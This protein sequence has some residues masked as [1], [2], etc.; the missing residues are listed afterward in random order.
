[1]ANIRY[2]AEALKPLAEITYPAGT[3][4]HQLIND[5]NIPENL[6]DH[7]MVFRNGGLVKDYDLI[8]EEHENLTIAIVQRGGGGGDKNGIM[9]IVASIAIAYA[10]PYAAPALAG[11]TGMSVAVATAAISIVGSLVVSA[12]IPPASL[13]GDT[14]A[15]TQSFE[16]PLAYNLTGQT[17]TA[18][19]YGGVPAI[20]GQIRFF[21]YIGAQTKVVQI[22]KRTVLSSLYDF[23]LGDVLIDGVQIGT[24]P[25]V[26][27]GATFIDHVNTKNPDLKYVT[28]TVGYDQLAFNLSSNELT[29]VTR[30]NADGAALTMVFP[31]GLAKFND[32]GNPTNYSVDLMVEFRKKGTSEW[33]RV[34]ASQFKT[35]TVTVSDRRVDLKVANYDQNFTVSPSKNIRYGNGTDSVSQVQSGEIKCNPN[36]FK[37]GTRQS[38]PDPVLDIDKKIDNKKAP[39]FVMYNNPYPYYNNGGYYG[40]GNGYSG[41]WWFGG[42]YP[43]P[44]PLYQRVSSGQGCYIPDGT[45]TT[46]IFNGATAQ[47]NS[48][49]LEVFF[50]EPDVYEIKVKRESAESTNTR[51]L[52]Q[53][54]IT[55]LETLKNET[56]VVL[57]HPHTLLEMQ[58][59]SSERLTGNVDNLSAFVSKRI[60]TIDENGF[61]DDLIETGNPALIALDIL[62]NDANRE[63]LRDDQIDFASFVD[64]AN[65][66][67]ELVTY[68]QGGKTYTHQK[69]EFNGLVVGS[70]VQEAVNNVLANGRAQLLMLQ[71]GKFGVLIDRPKTIPKQLITPANSWGFK[72]SRS[73]PYYPDALRV[74][75]VD[76]DLN[77]ATTEVTVYSDGFDETN[78]KRF[79]TLK[80]TGIINY[81]QAYRYARYM[82]AQARYR[83]EIFSVNMD[84]ENLS[85]V[86]GDLVLVQ[87]DVPKL[88]GP[89]L[90][91][92][93]VSG[94]TIKFNQRISIPDDASYTVRTLE[95]EVKSGKVVSQLDPS[96]VE[97]ETAD[98]S[99]TPDALLA[100]GVT[101]KV[102]SPYLVLAVSP[103]PDLTATIDLAPYSEEVYEEGDLP[104]WNPNF[105][106]DLITSPS[107]AVKNM[108]AVQAITYVDRQPQVDIGIKWEITGNINML[109]RV[110]VY[111]LVDGQEGEYCGSSDSKELIWKMSPIRKKELLNQPSGKFVATPFSKID[112]QGV[113]A[114]LVYAIQG[115][116]TPPLPIEG[117]GVNILNN[118]L[119]DIFW[120]K[121]RDVD[122]A[123]YELR[124]TPQTKDPQWN[125]A[126][127]LATV[128]WATNRT[129]AGARTGSY[130]IMI[131][132]TSENKSAPQ[133]LRTS[134]ETLPSLDFVIA[135]NDAPTWSGNKINCNTDSGSLMLNGGFGSV[136]DRIGYY[137]FVD[138]Y[139]ANQIQELRCIN[140]LEG[141][142]VSR[143]DVMENWVPLASA[144]PI[145][146][147]T[148][149]DFDYWLEAATTNDQ[150]FMD[151]WVPLSG[152][153]ANPIEGG[154]VGWQ[155]WRRIESADLTG[156]LYKFRI[157]MASYNPLVN[158][159]MTSGKTDIDV[160]DRFE[161]YP[162]V[163]VTTS[164]TRIDFIPPFRNIPA[165]AVSID[166]NSKD[167]RYEINSKTESSA[168]IVLI[169]NLTN[170]QTTGQIDVN[171]QGYGK[172]RATS[173]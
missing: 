75:Y 33:Q 165:I 124:F 65:F 92:V 62:T 29:M 110:D 82:M 19:M 103:S 35:E 9:G 147:A 166:G 158:I 153:N 5:L 76:P 13:G 115:D 126:S 170:E 140:Y 143:G 168:E 133:W 55:S 41:T 138:V 26:N 169:D 58:V 25:A 51:I 93:E 159:K 20:Y 50:N 21:P 148:E 163:V 120:K 99:I 118:S 3:N 167:I 95:G 48:I 70:T 146:S 156:Q 128:D 17:N 37:E 56:P 136:T 139:D 104:I 45:S 43:P 113:N 73:Y 108:T 117:F 151:D 66:C 42:Y 88:G 40:A 161:S 57:D 164:G 135:I 173:L 131:K 160:L 64:L 1:M 72:G 107:V 11:A 109:K 16:E 150:L 155:E 8:I 119:I 97:I 31:R 87:H 129:S 137:E 67:S 49:R 46:V 114:E 7:L 94:T 27:F 172:V 6:H 145:A 123:T 84:I 34:S 112:L 60:R 18:N 101:N 154:G 59:Q 132:D 12:L 54:Q 22:G 89:S 85:V 100:I 130:G 116:D 2:Q 23:G 162:D 144:D 32:Q 111:Y 122:I 39:R 14:G 80:T 134:V 125:A 71:N 52:D 127:H 77:W 98:P 44:I 47:P 86:R 78:A 152:E 10:A 102:T 36:W 142:G 91:V 141:Y 121:T 96:T 53:L 28:N 24:Q 15:N 149:S 106:G 61:V 30:P 171:V 83:S 79:E 105:S 4:I 69:Y 90:R 68:E 38:L 81:D 157:A 63:P 74:E